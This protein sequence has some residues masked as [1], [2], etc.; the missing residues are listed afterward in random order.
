MQQLWKRAWQFLKMLNL[1]LPYNPAILL[2]GIQP[3]VLNGGMFS[4]L[5]GIYLGLDKVASVRIDPASKTLSPIPDS[6]LSHMPSVVLVLS[7]DSPVSAPSTSRH[8]H[9]VS[10][11]AETNQDLISSSRTFQRKTKFSFSEAPE[12]VS[13]CFINVSLIRL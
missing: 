1:K 13:L 6:I 7:S 3:R 5:L 10:K 12:K 8:A 2:L 9:L 4:F 11:K